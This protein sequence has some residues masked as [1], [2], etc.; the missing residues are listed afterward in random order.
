MENWYFL[1]HF[2]RVV[3]EKKLSNYSPS[4]AVGKLLTNGWSTP[5][6][7]TSFSSK[8]ALHIFSFVMKSDTLHQHIAEHN[9]L[10]GHIYPKIQTNMKRV[11]YPTR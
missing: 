4:A 6:Y 9:C 10:L 1:G 2:K 3:V 5:L 7:K 11:I 8:N